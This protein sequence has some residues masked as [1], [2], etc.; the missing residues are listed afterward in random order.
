MPEIK[1][2]FCRICEA[3]CGLKVTVEGN[4]AVKIEPDKEHVVSK[5]YACIKGI[6]FDAVQYNPDRVLHPLKRQESTW[7]RISWDQAISEIGAKIKE[8]VDR[9]GPQTVSTVVGNP[10]GFANIHR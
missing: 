4:R 5:G 6:R 7:R 1:Y 10:A 2:T 3:A 9:Y 8:L